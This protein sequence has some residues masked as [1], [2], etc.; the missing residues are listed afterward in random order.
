MSDLRRAGVALR[1]RW[2]WSRRVGPQRAWG[3]LLE[4]DERAVV[5]L[6]QVATSSAVGDGTTTLFWT[7]NWIRGSSIRVLAPTISAA[8]PRRRRCTTVVD[9]LNER[10]WVRQISGPRTMRL[11]NEFMEQSVN[12]WNTRH[13]LLEMVAGRS[14]F[15][16][17][18][19][20]SNVHWIDDT[21][22]AQTHLE[23]CC[24]AMGLFFF[25]LVLH[26]RCWTAQR[27]RRHGLQDSDACIL[28]DQE[29][30]MMEHIILGCVYSREVWDMCLR[31]LRLDHWI[32]VRE[33]ETMAWWTAAR[34]GIPKPL[35]RGFDSLLLLIKWLLWKE[36]NSCTFNRLSLTAV[37][38]T[39]KVGAEAML[40]IAAGNK[41]LAALEDRRATITGP[42]LLLRRKTVS[43]CSAFLLPWCAGHGLLFVCVTVVRSG[44]VFVCCSSGLAS[45]G[46]P[47]CPML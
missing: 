20:W 24:A 25:W 38:L 2:K 18:R 17:I 6:F 30:E 21:T 19:L 27:R 41:H 40:W 4:E 14:I 16:Q 42:K 39:E 10:A 47:A 33:E 8:V 5:A 22:R 1:V 12:P 44:V 15:G 43:K 35:R 11:I 3:A 46:F 31:W 45:L 36:R 29:I 7:D 23:D 32:Q 37:Q 34:K 13:L 9:A 26:G 28:C